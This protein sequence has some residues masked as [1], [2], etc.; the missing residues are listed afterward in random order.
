MRFHRTRIISSSIEVEAG[1]SR[2]KFVNRMTSPPLQIVPL[3]DAQILYKLAADAEADGWRMVSRLMAEWEQRINRFDGPGEC[4]HSVIE[5]DGSVIAVGGLNRD[6]FA[7][8]PVIGRIRRLYVATTHR[9]RGVGSAL[10]ERLTADAAGHFRLLHLRTNNPVAA[11]FYE[12]I[13]FS[14]VTGE[15]KWTHRIRLEKR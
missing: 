1:L 6:P 15:P 3:S 14:R 13:G 12:A 5:A 8:D 9:R 11:D 2:T 10:M 4:I 7:G